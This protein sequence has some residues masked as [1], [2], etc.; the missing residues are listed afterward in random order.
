MIS[1]NDAVYSMLGDFTSAIVNMLRDQECAF[2]YL[3][4]ANQ[5]QLIEDAQLRVENMI[6]R[7]VD[8]VSANHTTS[9][10][11]SLEQVVR[12]GD[13]MKITLGANA[14][15]PKV[16]DLLLFDGVRVQLSLI[17]ADE[18]MGGDVPAPTPD[19]PALGV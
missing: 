18:Y 10:S 13:R 19:Q 14:M 9:F 2:R 5:R 16:R 4:E 15:D 11:C 3:S 1:D 12:K 7:C 17:D 6:R 8:L